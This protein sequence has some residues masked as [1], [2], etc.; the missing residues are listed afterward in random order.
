MLFV[1]TGHSLIS[2]GSFACADNVDGFSFVH[3]KERS[4]SDKGDLVAS[5]IMQGANVCSYDVSAHDAP[6]TLVSEDGILP[7]FLETTQSITETN[8]QI[9]VCDPDDDSSAIVMTEPQ[10]AY[11]DGNRDPEFNQVDFLRNDLARSMMAL[12]LPSAVPLL[13]KTY[14]RRI[15]KHDQRKKS[16]TH[17]DQSMLDSTVRSDSTY[18]SNDFRLQGILIVEN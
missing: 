1:Y 9:M 4:F 5:T 8:D 16:A 12:L 2:N 6:K 14:Q 18:E 7:N 17:L 13:K 11:L 3:D 15:P 10:A